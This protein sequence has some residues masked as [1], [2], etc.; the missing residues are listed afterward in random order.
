MK[1]LFALERNEISMI[2][3]N[4]KHWCKNTYSQLWCLLLGCDNSECFI[5]LF[6]SFTV[7]F[8]GNIFLYGK[9]ILDTSLECPDVGL[10]DSKSMYVATMTKKTMYGSSHNHQP[11]CT[12]VISKK[13]VFLSISGHSCAFKSL[14]LKM[15]EHGEPK[16]IHRRLW[17]GFAP[18]WDTTKNCKQSSGE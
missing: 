17:F 4:A 3:Q 13:N 6:I 9:R 2:F 12:I 14:I 18:V 15:R 16:E 5:Y 1:V 8:G 7:S 11:F 10:S